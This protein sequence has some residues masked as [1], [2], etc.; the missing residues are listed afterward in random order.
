MGQSL[1][2]LAD[3]QLTDD[4]I[5]VFVDKCL[6]FI[7]LHGLRSLGIYRRNAVQSKA[8][9]LAHEL[10]RKCSFHILPDQYDEHDCATVLKRFFR[11]LS[12]PLLNNS[13]EWIEA[14]KLDPDTRLT[15]FKTLIADMPEVN[16]QVLKRLL[17]HFSMLNDYQDSNGASV[18]NM[19]AI[20]APNLLRSGGISDYFFANACIQ[21]ITALITDFKQLYEINWVVEQKKTSIQNAMQKTKGRIHRSNSSDFIMWIKNKVSDKDLHFVVC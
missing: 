20:W 1:G 9:K 4:N 6:Q 18:A 14:S 2:N 3:K 7:E 15:T 8:T 19:A 11:E 17:H 13:D 5:P 10:E 21:V 12:E 16:R